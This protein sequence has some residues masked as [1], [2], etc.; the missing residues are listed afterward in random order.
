MQT[1]I[2]KGVDVNAADDEG[3][4]AFLYAASKLQTAMRVKGVDNRYKYALNSYE[5]T[6]NCND[7]MC[8]RKRRIEMTCES[9]QQ[10]RVIDRQNRCQTSATLGF[11]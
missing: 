10:T 6:R 2:D 4:T 9:S 1:L 3:N 8:I 7:F 11:D 5:S